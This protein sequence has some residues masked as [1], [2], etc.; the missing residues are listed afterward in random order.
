MFQKNN[1]DIKDDENGK[2]VRSKSVT[3]GAV[4]MKEI[5]E[6]ELN[7]QQSS[8][9]IIPNG[10]VPQSCVKSTKQVGTSTPKP[11]KRRLTFNILDNHRNSSALEE[12]SE[13]ITK[14]GINKVI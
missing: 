13:E 12:I 6:K 4:K 3:N 5:Q 14:D 9:S 10:K 7:H 8:S 11:I 2:L 1:V